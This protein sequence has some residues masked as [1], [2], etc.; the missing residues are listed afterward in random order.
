MNG[1]AASGMLLIDRTPKQLTMHEERSHAHLADDNN[2]EIT[3]GTHSWQ[4]KNVD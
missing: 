2:A 3:Q 1:Q 4:H